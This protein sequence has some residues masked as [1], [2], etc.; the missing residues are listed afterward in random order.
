MVV[1]ANMKMIIRIRPSGGDLC[2]QRSS[3]SYKQNSSNRNF[4]IIISHSIS[5][6]LSSSSCISSLRDRCR[7]FSSGSSNSLFKRQQIF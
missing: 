3:K 6:G 2:K 1:E 4:D 7:C 5:I